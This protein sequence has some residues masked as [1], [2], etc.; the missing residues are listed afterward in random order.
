MHNE[1]QPKLENK[2]YVEDQNV[3]GGILDEDFY[4]TNSDSEDKDYVDLSDA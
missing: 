4:F 3:R 1:V 2:F